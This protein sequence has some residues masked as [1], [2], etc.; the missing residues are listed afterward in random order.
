MG[1]AGPQPHP[2]AGQPTVDLPHRGA[3]PRP[4]GEGGILLKAGAS[5]GLRCGQCQDVG[6]SKEALFWGIS[7]IARAPGILY[8]QRQ[9]WL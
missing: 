8:F 2:K 1:K 9:R 7:E 3:G 4:S 6:E 5:V